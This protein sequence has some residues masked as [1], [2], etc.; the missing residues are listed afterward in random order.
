MSLFYRL[1]GEGILRQ[2]KITVHAMGAYID[3]YGRGG[4][5]RHELIH[6][7]QLRG[8]ARKEMLRLL[9]QNDQAADKTEHAMKVEMLCMIED[10]RGPDRARFRDRLFGRNRTINGSVNRGSTVATASGPGPTPR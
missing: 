9:E 7:L 3:E 4:I 6:E 5:G 8:V 2:P 10:I 1:F